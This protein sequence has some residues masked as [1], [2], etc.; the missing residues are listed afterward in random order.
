MLMAMI[1]GDDPA[2]TAVVACN[3]AAIAADEARNTLVVDLDPSR[4]A[5]AALRARS[6]PGINEI[7]RDGT[8]WPAATVSASAGRDRVVD[9]VPY[10]AGT[11]SAEAAAQLL[12][13]AAPRMSRYYD[14]VILVARPGDIAGGL[15]SALPSPEFVY[16]AQPGV[17]TI[18]RLKAE[19]DAMRAAG[20]LIRGVALWDAERPPPFSA[21]PAAN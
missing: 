2:I 5:S 4:C 16:C 15:A 11:V 21:A 7:L 8:A 6:A 12:A 3:L 18:A 10:G 14:S 1:T 13:D 9:L 20:A 17:T 19:L